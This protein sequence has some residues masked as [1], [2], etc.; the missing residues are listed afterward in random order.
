MLVVKL[1]RSVMLVLQFLNIPTGTE[2]SKRKCLSFAK[3]SCSSLLHQLKFLV[4]ARFAETKLH[5][6]IN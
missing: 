3:T 2:S 5:I 4:E 6:L 1:T